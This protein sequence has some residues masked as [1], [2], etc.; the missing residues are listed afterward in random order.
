VNLA[1]AGLWIWIY[2]NDR[3]LRQGIHVSGF[4]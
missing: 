2:M 3:E 4:V 1:T